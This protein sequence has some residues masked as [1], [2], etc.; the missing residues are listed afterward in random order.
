M[1]NEQ[2]LFKTVLESGSILAQLHAACGS[3]EQLS[4]SA[5]STRD[6]N[7]S[8]D[9]LKEKQEAIQTVVSDVNVRCIR[10][11]DAL[12]DLDIRYSAPAVD[13][14]V[15]ASSTLSSKKKSV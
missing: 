10:L 2:Q 9:L 4:G 8:L 15:P 1:K 5:L 11:F 14:D 7:A 13:S 12:L 6:G 3:L